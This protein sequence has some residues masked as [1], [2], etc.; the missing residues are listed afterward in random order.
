MISKS[1]QRRLAI[2][3]KDNPKVYDC[4]KPICMARMDELRKKLAAAEKVVEAARQSKEVF[5][6]II[7]CRSCDPT[8][9]FTCPDCA[10]G[11]AIKEALKAYDEPTK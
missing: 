11:Y 8:V 9:N 7:E 1:E 5:L 6:T 10:A 2:Q 3:L 4:E